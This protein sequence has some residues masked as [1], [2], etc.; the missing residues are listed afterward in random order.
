LGH[1]AVT[2]DMRHASEVSSIGVAYENVA[3]KVTS[4]T[5]PEGVSAVLIVLVDINIGIR[6]ILP[7]H[8][9]KSRGFL[10]TRNDDGHGS[11]KRTLASDGIAGEILIV[12][13][14]RNISL[15]VFEE[16]A[17]SSFS[18]AIKG[19]SGE[20]KV[21]SKV[22][23]EF[24][25]LLSIYFKNNFFSVIGSG[26]ESDLIRIEMYDNLDFNFSELDF[27]RVAL[28][29]GLTVKRVSSQVGRL[30]DEFKREFSR[31]KGVDT[32][33]LN[34]TVLEKVKFHIGMLMTVGAK[35]ERKD[36]I[37]DLN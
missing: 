37:I 9:D 32:V 7:I 30:F 8:T 26:E 6:S 13:V 29:S 31:V 36:I 17:S 25:A 5:E 27:N 23:I 3:F 19:I 24:K 18:K 14:V 21:S 35:I 34:N 22:F 16:K 11:I 33:E 12:E 4:F 20:A 2:K 10:A 15:S 1:S 28:Y